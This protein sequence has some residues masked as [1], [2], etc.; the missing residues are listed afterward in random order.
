MTKGK[1]RKKASD[2]KAVEELPYRPCVGI[3]LLNA[4]GKVFVAQRIDMPSKA[5]QMPQ[6]GIDEGE[7]PL[8]AA[9][10]ELLEETGYGGG[11]WHELG[12]VQPNPAM[13]DN[14]CHHFLARDVELIAEPEPDPG[15]M[16]RVHLMRLDAIRTAVEAGQIKHTLA[17]SA[18]SRV[19]PLWQP[20]Y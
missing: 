13:Q 19:F 6:G 12:A 4:Q 7:T 3:M 16:L 11:D 1:N 8:E 20:T 15:E 5:W 9:K 18:L 14:L 2:Q 17:L 10:R